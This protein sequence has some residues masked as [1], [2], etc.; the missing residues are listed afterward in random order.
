MQFAETMKTSPRANFVLTALAFVAMIGGH[1]VRGQDRIPGVSASID[2]PVFPVLI[3]NELNPLL[4]LVIEVGKMEPDDIFLRNDVRL[5]SISFSRS[6]LT[7][8]ACSP[9]VPSIERTWA[10]PRAWV[11][12]SAILL[13]ARRS[14]LPFSGMNSAENV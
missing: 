13:I 5:T 2:R 11:K 1:P 6:A 14:P 8:S 4:R 12:P 3:R 7:S 9:R 10:L